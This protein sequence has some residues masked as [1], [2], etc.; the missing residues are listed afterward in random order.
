MASLNSV[1]QKIFRA[2]QHLETIS[3]ELEG[4]FKTNPGKMV[5]EPESDPNNP[6]F[7]FQPRTSIPARF[8]LIAGDC[9]QNLRSSLD[10]LVWELVLAANGKPTEKNMFPICSTIEAFKNQIRRHRLDGVPPDAVTE[11]DGLQPYHLGQDWQKSILWVIDDFTNINKHRR[12]PL[13][14]LRAAQS[15]ITPIEINGELWMRGPVPALDDNAKFHASQVQ[16][17]PKFFAC[18]TFDE[19]PAKGMEVSS[20]LFGWINFVANDLVPKFDRFFK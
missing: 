18:I 4:Y 14:M 5:M 11:I 19:G 10:Y 1:R 15:N 9:F 17:N 2:Q 8:G 13:T 6:A 3:L 12:V 16:V 7:T 20:S